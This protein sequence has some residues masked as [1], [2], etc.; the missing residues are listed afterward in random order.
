MATGLYEPIRNGIAVTNFFNG[1]LLSAEDLSSEQKANDASRRLLG[2]AIGD[3]VAYGLEVSAASASPGTASPAITVE[4]GLAVNRCGNA[5]YLPERTDLAI[6]PPIDGSAATA[7]SAFS[8]CQPLQTGTYVTGEGVYLL[9]VS[10]ASF[11]DGRAPASGLGNVTASCSAK[12]NVQSVQFRLIQ[13]LAADTSDPAK[14]R[15]RIAYQCL[16]V[17]RT[18][19]F[20]ISPFGAQ[21]GQYGLI[22]DLRANFLTDCDV[23]I[24]VLH[25][26]AT[27]GLD[28]ID[29]WSARR[30]VTERSNAGRWSALVGERRR[31]E[32]G[33]MFL[34]F[35]DQIESIRA[36]EGNLQTISAAQRFD[37]LPPIGWLPVRNDVSPGGFDIATFFGAHASLDIAPIDSDRLRML[38]Q[39]A[40]NCEPVAL[41]TTGKIQLYFVWEN[42]S[43]VRAGTANQLVLVFASPALPYSGSARFGFAT[44][45]RSRIA[46]Q[47]I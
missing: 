3:G 29:M 23:P 13:L 39:E 34:Q 5:L 6:F 21:P 38:S 40:L 19:S 22:D 2:R 30:Q 47:V 37:F 43:A 8:S 26:T 16:G 42:L 32:T 18:R 45:G 15:N 17:D 36:T 14:A 27:G 10:P 9:T 28:F 46:R 25:W 12:Y 4:A 11:A 33:A 20:A 35:Q 41:A 1:R 24:A 44:W 31:A 7:T